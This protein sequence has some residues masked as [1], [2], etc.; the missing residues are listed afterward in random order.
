MILSYNKKW[1]TKKKSISN[2]GMMKQILIKWPNRNPMV[3]V[4]E[5]QK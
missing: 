1:K 5:L 4:I 3:E 2:W